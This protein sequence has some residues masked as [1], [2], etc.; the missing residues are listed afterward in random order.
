[1]LLA[2]GSF[3]AGLNLASF[4][5]CFLGLVLALAVPTVS[6]VKQSVLFIILGAA[7]VVGIGMTFWSNRKE[8]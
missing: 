5:L 7:L 3:L 8:S 6:W 2:L 1:M 4:E